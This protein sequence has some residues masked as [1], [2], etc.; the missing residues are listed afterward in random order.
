MRFRVGRVVFDWGAGWQLPAFDCVLVG[1]C[2]RSGLFWF[3]GELLILSPGSFAV[4][5][6]PAGVRGVAVLVVNLDLIDCLVGLP[7]VWAR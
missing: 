5:G 3:C 2:C 1:L 4:F 6:C 7:W